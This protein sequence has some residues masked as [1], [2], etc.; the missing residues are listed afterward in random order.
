VEAITEVQQ[1]NKQTFKDL[2]SFYHV[3]EEAPDE[4]DMRDIHIEEFEG[5]RDVEGPPLDS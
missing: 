3:Q 1:R 5:K 2:L 4:D